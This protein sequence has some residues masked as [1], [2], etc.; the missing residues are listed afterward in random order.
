MATSGTDLANARYVVLRTFRR[1]GTPVDTP[2]WFHLDGDTMVLRTK[3]GPKTRRVRADPRVQVWVCD[4]RGRRV[5]AGP[6]WVGRA[7]L[8]TG[9][10]AQAAEMLL[11]RRYGWQWNVVPLLRIPGVT[12][13]HRDLPLREK[14]RRAGS[15][16]LWPDS[17]IIR[18][19]LTARDHDPESRAG[20]S[21]VL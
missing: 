15:R 6:G 20:R 14:I 13:V 21:A 9:A 8:L 16:T 12:N 1:D 19:Q 18:I 11:H 2:V 3:R 7:E 4:H 17:E 10:D 5:D